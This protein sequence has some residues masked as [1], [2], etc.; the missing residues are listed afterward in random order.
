L[1]GLLYAF[2]DQ[3]RAGLV[4]GWGRLHGLQLND[5]R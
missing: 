4:P 3:T 5:G 1:K 2:M